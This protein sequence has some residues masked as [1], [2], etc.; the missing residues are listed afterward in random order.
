[1][2]SS[3]SNNV[4][5]RG[6]PRSPGQAVI[7]P[8]EIGSMG[9]KSRGRGRRG[10]IWEVQCKQSQFL[11]I[12][13]HVRSWTHFD[14]LP[15]R[16]LR[17]PIPRSQ[18]AMLRAGQGNLQIVALDE[19]AFSTLWDTE[20]GDE[21]MWSGAELTGVQSIARPALIIA[22]VFKGALK[23]QFN[24]SK[25]K[26]PKIQ[27]REKRK[28]KMAFMIL[29]MGHNAHWRINSNS[30]SQQRPEDSWQ[31]SQVQSYPRGLCTSPLVTV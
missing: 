6:A 17:P 20:K 26:D 23:R 19:E 22:D 4:E 10:P 8:R 21:R 1:M 9:R 13:A 28:V 14:V 18:T 25:Y 27:P 24:I 30:F 15:Q 31:S 3:T 5:Q 29:L 12:P 7:S 2:C 16:P 11:I